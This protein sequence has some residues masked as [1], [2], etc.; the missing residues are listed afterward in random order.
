MA[1]RFFLLSG[2]YRSQLNFADNSLEQAA[3]SIK[4]VNEFVFRLADFLD[5][6]SSESAADTAAIS[7]VENIRKRYVAALEN[8]LDVPSALA[9]VF[10]LVSEGNRLLDKGNLGRNS[11]EAFLDFMN[12]DFDSIFG[13]VASKTEISVTKEESKL[14]EE[15][16]IARRTKDWKKSDEIRQKLLANGIEVQDTPEG[17]KWRRIRKST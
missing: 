5:S 2:H 13:V 3:A 17:Q 10:D 12:S 7:F 9:S 14:L 15:R 4:R 11:A 6:P 16:Q 8:D 1:L